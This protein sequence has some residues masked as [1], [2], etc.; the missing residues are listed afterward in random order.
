MRIIVSASI[1]ALLTGPAHSQALNLWRDDKP[2]M[3]ENQKQKNEEVDKA[4]RSATE[5]LPSKKSN[6]DP[7]QNVRGADQKQTTSASPRN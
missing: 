7:W 3:S 4:Y 2:A 1:I 5:Q 6:A